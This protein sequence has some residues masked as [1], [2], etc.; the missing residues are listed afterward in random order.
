VKGH[1]QGKTGEEKGGKGQEERRIF[2]MTVREPAHPETDS[3]E[4]GRKRPVHCPVP[5]YSLKLH[6]E[7]HGPCD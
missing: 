2:L 1:R 7:K 5:P 4:K 3:R 6:S